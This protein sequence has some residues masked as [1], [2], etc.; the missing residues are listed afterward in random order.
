MVIGQLKK[1]VMAGQIWDQ[2]L[3]L[4]KFIQRAEELLNSGNLLAQV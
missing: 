2:N 3:A 4:V 1:K